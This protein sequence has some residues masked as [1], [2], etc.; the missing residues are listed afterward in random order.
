MKLQ[1]VMNRSADKQGTDLL[2][3]TRITLD[4]ATGPVALDQI[5]Q[6][7]PSIADDIRLHVDFWFVRRRDQILRWINSVGGKDVTADDVDL[8]SDLLLA[9][10][11]R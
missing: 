9:A 8:V 10:C 1:A 2:D 6:G 3:I 5:S 7:D 4:Q 11:V